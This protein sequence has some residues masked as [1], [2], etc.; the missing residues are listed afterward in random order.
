MRPNEI[1]HSIV[2]ESRESLILV[3]GNLQPVF[4]I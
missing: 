1:R 3:T 2:D 4:G